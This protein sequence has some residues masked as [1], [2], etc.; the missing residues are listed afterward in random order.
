[1]PERREIEIEGPNVEE[2]IYRGLAELGVRR[3]SVDI[4]ILTEGS[5]GLFG[6]MG[7]SP[8]RVRLVA[9]DTPPASPRREPSRSAEPGRGR[10]ARRARPAAGGRSGGERGS[11]RDGGS[12]E[13]RRPPRERVVRPRSDEPAVEPDWALAEERVKQALLSTLAAMEFD[14]T[15]SLRV[16]D[17]RLVGDLTGPDAE[18]L[19]EDG[20]RPLESLQLLVAAR[21]AKDPK[22]R[23][24]VVLDAAGF[25]ARQQAVVVQKA[26]EAA[27]RVKADRQPVELEPM[28][29]SDRRAAHQSLK[30]DPDVETRSEG[31]GP[32]Q[33]VVIQ[34]KSV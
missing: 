13:G 3:D 11:R 19:I 28:N 2:A 18:R 26:M 16:A 12:R 5:S 34:P 33:R 17:G 6:L 27:A 9:R 24:P 8:A 10:E 32:G 20:G 25:R 1:M 4:K 22:T 15:A 30:D 14:V 23:V 21:A 7:S 31:E 29:S